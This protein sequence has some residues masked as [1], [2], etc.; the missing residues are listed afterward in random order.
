MNYTSPKVTYSMTIQ[1]NNLIISPG[2][3]H[4]ID[5]YD[6]IESLAYHF[7]PN[8]H[9]SIVNSKIHILPTYKPILKQTIPKNLINSF[10]DVNDIELGMYNELLY[11]I[12]SE[13]GLILAR[14]SDELYKII[15]PPKPNSFST[16]IL[17]NKPVIVSMSYMGRVINYKQLI[18]DNDV[19]FN[20]YQSKNSLDI[21][22]KSYFTKYNTIIYLHDC[23]LMKNKD[24]IH[25][26]TFKINPNILSNIAHI[27]ISEI[28]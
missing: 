28:A 18:L 15:D 17:D 11:I 24:V 2:D 16:T 13:Q 6:E 14:V 3:I 12:L 8:S 4:N 25:L 27:N 21:L 19:L 26:I 5:N 7:G 22:S 9:L 20:E 23:K 1:G 10:L